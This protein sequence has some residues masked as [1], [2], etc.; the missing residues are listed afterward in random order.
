A[1]A[2][3]IVMLAIF[4]YT[5]N[6]RAIKRVRRGIRAN[7]LTA[8]LFRDSPAVGFRAQGRVL[9]G[10]LRL[11]LLAIVPILV[12]IVPCVLLLAQ[13][14]LWYQAKPLPVGE[15]TV[16]TMKLGGEVGSAMPLVELMPTEA[17]EDLSGPVRITSQREV[18]WNI[19][20]REAGYHR[21]LFRVNGEP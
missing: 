20:T 14:G 6:Q 7:L 2:T 19:R 4:K 17:V 9:L 8:R 11:L 1:V 21:L 16:V 15:E 10:A 5:S 3:G 12:M 18:C 13:M